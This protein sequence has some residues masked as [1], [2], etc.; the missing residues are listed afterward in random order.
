MEFANPR[1][2]ISRARFLPTLEKN[3]FTASTEDIGSSQDFNNGEESDFL[4][5]ILAICFM[6]FHVALGFFLAFRISFCSYSSCDT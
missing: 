1:D 2:W 3:L 6:I 5:F 4:V